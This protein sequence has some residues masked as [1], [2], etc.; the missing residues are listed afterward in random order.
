MT[1]KER[2][3]VTPEKVIYN[4]AKNY[5]SLEK[6]LVNQLS[7]QTP[8]HHLT[9]GTN[10]EN[11][12]LTLFERIIPRKFCI[13]QSVFIIDSYGQISAEVDIAVFDEQYTPYIFNYGKIKFIPI[14][15]VAVAVQCKSNSID[16]KVSD[17]AESIQDLKTAMNAVVRTQSNIVDNDIT[18]EQQSSTQSSTRPILILC[19]LSSEAAKYKDVF[20]I[21]LHLNDSR[22]KLI[23]LIKK[24]SE[25][26]K[27]WVDD[28]NHYG[29]DRYPEG[30]KERYKVLPNKLTD[31]KKSL[32]KLRVTEEKNENVTLS[33][34]FQLNQLLMLINNPLFF[35]HQSYVKMFNDNIEKYKKRSES[36][37]QTN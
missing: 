14:E 21:V 24:E 7:L 26:L 27:I 15:A 2:E 13:E 20:D 34:T 12:W 18:K 29:H 11:V 5:E 1:K 19:A 32:S 35:P 4:L 17:W 9:T 23:K 36:N 10:R 37:G 28:L 22:T 3:Q 30:E 25:D 31:T 6:S 16:N 33:L 8:N